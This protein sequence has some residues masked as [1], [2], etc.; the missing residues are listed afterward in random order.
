VSYLDYVYSF[1]M[2]GWA[3]LNESVVKKQTEISN[4]A[5]I[6]SAKDLQVCEEMIK[7]GCRNC[8]E[9]ETELYQVLLQNVLESQSDYDQQMDFAMQILTELC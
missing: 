4:K 5:G 1:K 6:K 8:R 2:P 3:P 9:K 7:Q